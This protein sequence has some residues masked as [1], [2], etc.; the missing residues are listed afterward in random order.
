MD[1][2]N[3]DWKTSSATHHEQITAVF[4]SS[5]VRLL[6]DCTRKK[7]ISFWIKPNIFQ[8]ILQHTN[9]QI[10]PCLYKQTHVKSLETT[11]FTQTLRPGL[12]VY[13]PCPELLPHQPPWTLLGVSAPSDKRWPVKKKEAKHKRWISSLIIPGS[14]SIHQLLAL[15][16]L[17]LSWKY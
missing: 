1:T 10:H 4:G 6:I 3:S 15:L 5:F 8:N 17:P 9:I 14:T 13:Y 7:N 11:L 16:S 2:L 12:I